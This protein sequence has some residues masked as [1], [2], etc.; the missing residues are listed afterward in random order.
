LRAINQAAG[1][2]LY[3]PR[4]GY[5]GP[6]S[7]TF[8]ATGAGGTSNTATISITVTSP[9]PLLRKLHLR[10]AAF[11]AATPANKRNHKRAGGKVSYT[12]SQKATARFTVDSIKPGVLVRKRCV[13][14]TRRNSR[15]KQVKRCT[16]FIPVGH[17]RHTDRAGNN[18]LVFSGLVN[19]HPLVPNRY[20]LDAI[21]KN[22][23][24]A[25]QIARA[26]FRIIA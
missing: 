25:S 18:S 4:P 2:V 26:L 14:A 15:G 6:D 5:R 11:R 16:R 17:F 24:G 13:A 3:T 20:R 23:N 22:A 19:G 12:D 7:F 9:P 21:A 10:P 8:N 1:T